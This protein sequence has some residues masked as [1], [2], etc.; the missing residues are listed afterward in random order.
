MLRARA[1]LL[2]LAERR[3][4]LVERARVQR[5]QLGRGLAGTDAAGAVLARVFRVVEEIRQQPLVVAGAVALLVAL[6]PRRAFGWLMK[7]W[8]AW[9]LVRGAQRLWQRLAAGA[10][11]PS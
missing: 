3:A 5:E 8:S 6:R 2:E 10:A 1:K 7:G 11:A 4:R 9:R